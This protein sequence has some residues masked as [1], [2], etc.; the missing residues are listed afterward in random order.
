MGDGRSIVA[1]DLGPS[2]FHR[3]GKILEIRGP[4]N[5]DG[6]RDARDAGF[7]ERDGAVGVGVLL[8][9]VEP[10]GVSAQRK[11]PSSFPEGLSYYPGGV[12]LSHAVARAVSSAMRSLTAVFGMG[13][14][15]T[16][17]L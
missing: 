7:I 17:A 13:T 14:G 9:V 5:A 8:P 1:H 2:R 16:S 6:G 15:V 11:R 3:P 4:R 10:S 12:L